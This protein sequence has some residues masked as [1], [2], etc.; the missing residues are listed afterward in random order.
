[1]KNKQVFVL[2][3]VLMALMLTQVGCP[4]QSLTPLQSYVLASQSYVTAVNMITKLAGVGEIDADKAK[5]I[6]EY[7]ILANSAL[8]AWEQALVQGESTS[9]AM[10]TF[11]KAIDKL[12]AVNRKE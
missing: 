10:E 4:Q 12:I 8:N 3:V 1:M 6:Q 2:F 11:D 9:Q 5:D 7:I